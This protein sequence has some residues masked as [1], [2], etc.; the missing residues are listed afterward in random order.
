MSQTDRGK[1]DKGS[2]IGDKGDGK[3]GATRN[4]SPKQTRS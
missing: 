1:G 3:S 4:R 2:A